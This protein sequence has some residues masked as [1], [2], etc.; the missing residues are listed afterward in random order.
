MEVLTVKNLSKKYANFALDGVTFDVRAGEIMGFIGKNG[1]GKTT[2]LK[3][4]L[5]FVHPDGGEI[6]FFGTT[7]SE[8]ESG[9]KSRIGFVSGGVDYYMRKKLKTIT[10]VT[11]SFYDNWDGDAY[12]KYM[13]LFEL[14]ET[15]TPEELSAGMKVKYNLALALSHKAEFLLLDEP[16]SGLDPVSRD[17]LLEVFLTLE[18]RGVSILFSTHITGDLDKCADRITYINRGK[19]VACAELAKFTGAYRSLLIPEDKLTDELKP[20]LIGVRIAKNGFSAIVKT[21]DAD[22]LGLQTTPADLETVMVHLEKQ[23]ENSGDF[24]GTEGEIL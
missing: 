21:E 10:G 11:R 7:F 24:I 2:T 23:S 17:D 15:K 9:I 1:A 19:I 13:R 12:A 5:N 6:K 20:K 16:T 14:D 4:L 8:N 18:R 3:S 22:K